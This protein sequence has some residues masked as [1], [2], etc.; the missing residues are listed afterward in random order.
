LFHRTDSGIWRAAPFDAIPWV[1]HGFGS[2]HTGSPPGN[3]ATLRQ[4]QSDIVVV[5]SGKCGRIGEGDALITDRPGWRIGVRTADC[6]PILLVDEQRRAVAA[7]HAGWRGSILGIA[8]RTVEAM[9]RAFGSRP[10]SLSAAIGPG[11]NMCCFE[12][13]PEVATQFRKLFPERNDLEGRTRMDLVEANRR[14]LVLAGLDPQRIFA[15]APCTCCTPAEF[16]S[17]RRDREPAGRM[18]SW[19]GILP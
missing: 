13:G 19:I 12:V 1:E 7:V 5:A 3:L 16:H 18:V 2:R 4:V 15:G 10:A 14:E 9:A 17:W 8:A 6:L 11:I